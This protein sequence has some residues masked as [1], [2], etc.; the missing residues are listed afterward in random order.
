MSTELTQERPANLRPYADYSIERKA[1][2]LALVEANDGN[3]DRTARDT[4]IAHQT[5]RFWYANKDRFSNVQSRKQVELAHLAESN[6]Y[7]L[8][9]SIASHDLDSASLSQKASAFGI[10]VDKMQLLRNQPT[11]IT[12]TQNSDNL[13]IIL[14]NVLSE[15]GQTIDITSVDTDS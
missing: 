14:Q 9:N 7:L 2:V 13:T 8:G 6:A 1:E 12:Q 3:I 4:G 10:M 11:S 15:L 5:I